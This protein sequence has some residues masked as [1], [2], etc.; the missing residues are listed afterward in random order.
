MQLNLWTLFL[1]FVLKI[2][3]FEKRHCTACRIILLTVALVFTGH[4]VILWRISQLKGIN[5]RDQQTERQT[6]TRSFYLLR[7]SHH[8]APVLLWRSLWFEAQ[9]RPN[10]VQWW[11]YVHIR[12][13]ITINATIILAIL[14]WM[15]RYRYTLLV[16]FVFCSCSY[17]ILQHAF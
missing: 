8:Q 14:R 3:N 10:G 5:H 1:G 7:K 11:F 9:S 15:Q 2:Y 12:L 13:K 17:L 16:L 4:C 6:D